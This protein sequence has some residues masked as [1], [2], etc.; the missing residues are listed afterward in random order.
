[1]YQCGWEITD[2]GKGG[3]REGFLKK[4]AEILGG[5]I[6]LTTLLR[7][8]SYA[9][10]PSMRNQGGFFDDP[11]FRP[12]GPRLALAVIA[13]GLLAFVPGHGGGDPA[14]CD[15]RRAADASERS[16]WDGERSPPMRSA[17]CVRRFTPSIRIQSLSPFSPLGEDRD[18]GQEA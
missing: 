6:S 4:Q 7:G 10:P 17:T 18:G 5:V 13:T 11:C 8:E 16:E 12:T 1:V 3:G 9:V 2:G 15:D 14:L